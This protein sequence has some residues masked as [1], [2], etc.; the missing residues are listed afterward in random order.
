M[1]KMSCGE[2]Y[3]QTSIQLTLKPIPEAIGRSGNW[4]LVFIAEKVKSKLKHKLNPLIG[5]NNYK[6]GPPSFL[7]GLTIGAAKMAL[8]KYCIPH[9]SY[10]C[11]IIPRSPYVLFNI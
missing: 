7:R 6:P 10:V 4:Q 8:S 11:T 2:V 1:F 5:L 3:H 9:M